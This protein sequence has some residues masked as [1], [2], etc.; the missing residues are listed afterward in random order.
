MTLRA[1]APGEEIEWRY[2]SQCHD[3]FFVLQGDITI[4]LHDPDAAVPL[5]VGKYDFVKARS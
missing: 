3:K 5:S 1:L 4:Q 2:H